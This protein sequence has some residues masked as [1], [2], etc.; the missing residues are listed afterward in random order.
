MHSC[1]PSPL[2]TAGRLDGPRGLN[3][4]LP[5][6]KV[7]A[8]LHCVFGWVVPVSSWVSGLLELLVDEDEGTTIL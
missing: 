3:R 8:I 1:E 7:F 2:L 5:A 6:L 4:M